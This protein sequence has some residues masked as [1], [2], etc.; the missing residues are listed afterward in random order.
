MGPM[1]ATRSEFYDADLDIF[2]LY[3]GTKLMILLLIEEAL[4]SF[5]PY[6]IMN[7]RIPSRLVL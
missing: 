4:Y 7:K 5:P 2:N 6:Q 1:G 3:K